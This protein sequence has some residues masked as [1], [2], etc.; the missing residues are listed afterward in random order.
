MKPVVEL[1]VIV[2]V[3]LNLYGIMKIIFLIIQVDSSVTVVIR[4]YRTG[5]S[6]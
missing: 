5:L 1:S 6:G 2:S 4:L 3:E